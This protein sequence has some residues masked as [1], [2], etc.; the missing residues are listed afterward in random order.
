LKKN[1]KAITKGFYKKKDLTSHSFGLRGKEEELEELHECQRIK[2]R[3][4]ISQISYSVLSGPM[5]REKHRVEV[6][7]S[8]SFF[9]RNHGMD[10]CEHVEKGNILQEDTSKL[11]RKIALASFLKKPSR[12]P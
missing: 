8:K 3:L 12:S 10:E 11:Q 6:G 5:G 4:C 1:C 2:K 7:R 9:I